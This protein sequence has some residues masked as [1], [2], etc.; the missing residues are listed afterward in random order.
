[1]AKNKLLFSTPNEGAS[2]RT[3]TSRVLT[4]D[5]HHHHHHHHHHHDRGIDVRE[6]EML[7]LYARNRGTSATS[8]YVALLSTEN[9]RNQ[10]RL[11]RV[12]LAPGQ[13]YTNTYA[14]PGEYVNIWAYAMRLNNRCNRGVDTVD[15]QLYGH[16]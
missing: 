1:M 6:Y 7:R 4:R 15:V 8:V 13:Q 16:K 3:G 5:G 2:L 11:A 9:G 10:Y 12:R 14:V